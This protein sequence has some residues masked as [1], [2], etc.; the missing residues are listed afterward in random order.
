[1]PSIPKKLY[2]ALNDQIG[3]E[4]A[5]AYLYLSMSAYCESI[6]F[7][8]ASSW[9]RIQW[10][11]ELGHAL[12][13][14]DFV[15]DRGDRPELPAIGKPRA[16]FSSLLDVFEHVLAHEREVTG[17][18]NEVYALSVEERDFA[19]Q[20]FLQWFVSEQVEEESTASE[21][22]ENLRLAGDDGSMLLL[23]DQQLGA[24]QPAAPAQG[25]QQA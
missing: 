20:A 14:I 13:M 11:E 9:L 23:I 15:L 12:K 8:G 16:E 24:R 3:K 22:V 19:S 1:M 17:A 25:G 10:E 2:E 6:N 18:I 21:I 7:K 4:V 5:S